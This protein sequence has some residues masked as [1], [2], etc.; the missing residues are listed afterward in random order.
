MHFM[1]L[2]QVSQRKRHTGVTV[3]VMFIYS[4]ILNEEGKKG[5][6]SREGLKGD[7]VFL[8][9]ALQDSCFTTQF[10]IYFI[11]HFSIQ[12]PFSRNINA[13][14]ELESSAGGEKR[15]KEKLKKTKTLKK[16]KYKRGGKK[17]FIFY[18]K[19]LSP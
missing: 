1:S 12:N 8:D 7:K 17:K 11:H 18:K 2:Q 16:K 4:R 15:W 9:Q 3:R 10:L 5:R 6:G 13:P 14:T 19:K